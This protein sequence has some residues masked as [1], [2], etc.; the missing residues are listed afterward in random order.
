[1]KTACSTHSTCML[2]SVVATLQVRNLPDDLHARLADRS[3]SLGVSMAEYV[4]RT[5]RADLARPT[6]AEWEADVRA[7]GS[8]RT[9][10]VVGA[11]DG[12]REEYDAADET[13]G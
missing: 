1:M 7:N 10:D 2:S 6:F 11:L 5:L 8:D 4:T 13:S 3:R 9:I 12:A